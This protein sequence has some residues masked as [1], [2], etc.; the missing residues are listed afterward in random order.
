MMSMKTINMMAGWFALGSVCLGA[1]LPEP[2]TILYGKV[3]TGSGP[4]EHLLTSG[5]LEFEIKRAD[6][7]P[8]TLKAQLEPL[9]EGK[10]SYQLRIP[11]EARSLGVETGEDVVPLGI[12]EST[13]TV[14]QPQFDEELATGVGEKTLSMRQKDRLSTYRLD[15]HVM[16]E[17]VDS[18]GDGMPDW[19]E[20][21][22]GLDKQGDDASLDSDGDGVNNLAEFL[23]G[24]TPK[25]LSEDD[26]TLDSFAKWREAHFPETKAVPLEAFAVSDPGGLGVSALARYAFDMGPMTVS[27]D[28]VQA[29]GNL[30]QPKVIDGHPA[31]TFKRALAA[32]DV[33]YLLEWHRG[34]GVWR[35][36]PGAVEEL[37]V[38]EGTTVWK[39]NTPIAQ[40]PSRLMR[41]RLIRN[42]VSHE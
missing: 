32:T 6:G 13:V 34:G 15:L 37:S 27:S 3:M 28:G 22:Y 20:D 21:A 25:E 1:S 10:Y 33:M 30:P 23:A 11:H 2:E 39:L 7:K 5:E 31:L 36:A 4:H 8:L 12:S 19:W 42:G 9:A 38:E 18:D 17:I 14:G 24:T 29:L 26:G 40:T 16:T 41:V 35:P